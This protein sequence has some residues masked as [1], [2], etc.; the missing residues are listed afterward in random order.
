MHSQCLGVVT[1]AR[2]VR[3][4]RPLSKEP[5]LDYQVMSDEDWE[6]EPEGEDLSVRSRG[7]YAAKWPEV[8]TF[9]MY[10]SGYEHLA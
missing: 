6:E 3:G 4:R 7:F 8:W 9:A 1:C 10:C 5:G 2:V